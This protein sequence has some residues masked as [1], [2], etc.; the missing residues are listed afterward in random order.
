MKK[1]ASII[2]GGVAGAVASNILRQAF[3]QFDHHATIWWA[4]K[5]SPKTLEI[6]TRY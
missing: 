2:I 4:K 5:T 1:L 6:L 3:K